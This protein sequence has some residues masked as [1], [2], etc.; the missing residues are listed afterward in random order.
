MMN[1]RLLGL[2]SLV[3][4]SAV[5][6]GCSE[7]KMEETQQTMQDTAA[8]VS[9]TV[10]EAAQDT[11]AAMSSAAESAGDMASDAADATSDMASDA[12]DSMQTMADDAAAA[13]G[14]AMDK[15]GDMASD[16]ADSDK[17]AADDAADKPKEAAEALIWRPAWCWPQDRKGLGNTSHYCIKS[18]EQPEVEDLAKEDGIRLAKERSTGSPD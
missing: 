10:N 1:K 6:T 5:F 4:V 2:L 14:D 15:A 17:D 13:T 11:G 8:S 16:A 12:S 3:L 18:L 7:K 9:D